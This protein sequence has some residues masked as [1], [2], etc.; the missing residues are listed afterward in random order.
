MNIMDALAENRKAVI[1]NVLAVLMSL[2]AEE[3]LDILDRQD[4][5]TVYD[6]IYKEGYEDEEAKG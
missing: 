4:V 5:D 2:E 6:M 1:N 3:I